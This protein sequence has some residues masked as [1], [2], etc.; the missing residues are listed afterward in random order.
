MATDPLVIPTGARREPT[1]RRVALTVVAAFIVAGISWVLLTDVLLYSLIRNEVVVARIE[2][3]KGWTFVGL[4]ALLLYVV[5]LRSASR[6]KRA[7]ETFFAVVNSI[8]DGVLLLGPD[9]R[10]AYANRAAVRM[11][12][13]G[14]MKELVGMGAGEFSRR[15]RVSFLDGRVVPP[16]Q[17]VSQRVFV[18]GGT[19][20]YKALIYPPGGAETVISVTAAG[21]RSDV[22]EPAE[23]VVS[24]MHDIT[25][26]ERIDRVRDQFIAAAAHSLKTPVAIIKGSSELL[27]CGKAPELVRPAAMIERQCGRIDR[28]VQN[29]LVLSRIRTGTLRLYPTELELRPLVEEVA[30]EMA[31][32]AADHSIATALISG[33]RVHGDRER[34]AMVVRNLID[35]AYRTSVAGAPLT[36]SMTLHDAD[37]EIGVSYQPLTRMAAALDARHGSDDLGIGRYVTAAIIEAH[38]GMIGQ[39]TTGAE[40][41]AWLRLPRIEANGRA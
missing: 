27:S 13:A 12:R 36:L 39:Y 21:V 3:A 16:D 4:A 2:T 33:A 38:G 30:H 26:S 34:L 15:Y 41:T 40:A 10:I 25:A 14:S 17:Y 23:V 37:I 5:T 24:V 32:A 1:E 19:L 20:Q 8:G 7:R 9:R 29:L 11:L 18:E 35:D 6:L 31:H 28:L 22:A